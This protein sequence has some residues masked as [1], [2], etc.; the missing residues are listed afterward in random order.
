MSSPVRR[1]WLL[2][3]VKFISNRTVHGGI[4]YNTTDV[5]RVSTTQIL[6]IAQY[7]ACTTGW[8][9]MATIC[10]ASTYNRTMNNGHYTWHW[11]HISP[12][13]SS[14]STMSKNTYINQRRCK[15]CINTQ[16]W[17]WQCILCNKNIVKVNIMIKF[18]YVIIYLKKSIEAYLIY[19]IITII[20]VVASAPTTIAMIMLCSGKK[21]NERK[22]MWLNKSKGTSCWKT[23]FWVTE[24]QSQN[25]SKWGPKVN[26]EIWHMWCHLGK[27]IRS[28]T[29]D[30]F[31]FLFHWSPHYERYILLKTPQSNQYSSKV[32][33]IERFSK[34]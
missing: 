2:R 32:V 25:V 3:S 6:N 10:I 18:S 16:R 5:K 20:A 19:G 17:W 9:T 34:Q 1:I 13:S 23:W 26:F 8:R 33:A 7:N 31:S 27:T 11:C 28:H 22:Y 30:I 29:C 15:S 14:E 21:P 12:A 4:V 24:V